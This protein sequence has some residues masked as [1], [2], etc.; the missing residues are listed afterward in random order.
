MTWNG[1]NDG[2]EEKKQSET[3][4]VGSAEGSPSS[5]KQI[6]VP[7]FVSVQPKECLSQSPL[8]SNSCTRVP[9]ANSA[10]RGLSRSGAPRTY[11]FV[12]HTTF[13]YYHDNSNSTLVV[14]LQ[15]C[16]SNQRKH[17]IQC[18]R[19]LVVSQPLLQVVDRLLEP[20]KH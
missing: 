15:P 14:T 2:S 8:R 12:A 9:G 18:V 5:C 20:Y 19:Q 7:A 3:L 4:P 6:L 16:E 13:H 11:T 10:I 1:K 17:D